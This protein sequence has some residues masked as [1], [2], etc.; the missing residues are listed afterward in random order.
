MIFF[1]LIDVIGGGIILLGLFTYIIIG[2]AEYRDKKK[3]AK[4]N[5]NKKP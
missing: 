4:L 5:K 3:Q 1:D 2:P